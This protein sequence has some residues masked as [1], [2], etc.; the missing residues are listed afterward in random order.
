MIFLE[1]LVRGLA[2]KTITLSE[3]RDLCRAIGYRY[4]AIH[5]HVSPEQWKLVRDV[6][7]YSVV[8]SSQTLVFFGIFK[9]IYFLIFFKFSF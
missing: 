7:V 3:W 5:L 1:E 4:S 2:E 8:I 9:S 6:L